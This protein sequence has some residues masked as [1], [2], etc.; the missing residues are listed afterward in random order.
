MSSCTII[1]HSAQGTNGEKLIFLTQVSV[2][3]LKL[4]KHQV[5]FLPEDTNILELL[6]I[7][8]N[9]GLIMSPSVSLPIFSQYLSKYPLFGVT[10]CPSP[11]FVVKL[12]KDRS[13]VQTFT[14]R[15]SMS[16]EHFKYSGYLPG[17][18]G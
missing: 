4:K 17:S 15:Y 3:G 13:H 18:T 8:K 1:E 5:F 9:F 2:L 11:N 6:A 7:F 12:Y 10:Y 16:H 14:T